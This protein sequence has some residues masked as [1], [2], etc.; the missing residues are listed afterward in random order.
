[1]KTQ[2]EL[3]LEL[4]LWQTRTELAEAQV[5]LWAA[6]GREAAQESVLIATELKQI[7]ENQNGTTTS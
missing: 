2:K 7:K 3:E 5:G 1:M 6:R 4:K